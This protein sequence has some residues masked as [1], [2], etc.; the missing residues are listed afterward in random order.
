MGATGSK[1]ENYNR[2]QLSRRRRNKFGAPEPPGIESD[3]LVSVFEW[4]Y[5]DLNEPIQTNGDTFP[6]IPAGIANKTMENLRNELLLPPGGWP[7]SPQTLQNSIKVVD[8]DQPDEIPVGVLTPR[9][10]KLNINRNGDDKNINKDVIAEAKYLHENFGGHKPEMVAGTK[11]NKNMGRNQS[12]EKITY[13][14]YCNPYLDNGKQRKDAH[15][16]YCGYPLW[17]KGV[18]IHSS[19]V[20]DIKNMFLYLDTYDL[21]KN[22]YPMHSTCNAYESKLPDGI[23]GVLNRLGSGVP[24]LESNA[25]GVGMSFAEHFLK[26]MPELF[27][28][29]NALYDATPKT[30]DELFECFKRILG[31]LKIHRGLLQKDSDGNKSS[32]VYIPSLP[33]STSSKFGQLYVDRLSA[34]ENLDVWKIQKI[35][36]MIAQGVIREKEEA[37]DIDVQATIEK[38]E[39]LL[40]EKNNQEEQ[41]RIDLRNQEEKLEAIREDMGDITADNVISNLEKSIAE[42][43]AEIIK[44]LLNKTEEE[45]NASRAA[46]G[47]A[48]EALT[49][50]QVRRFNDWSEHATADDLD[51][52]N[53][54]LIEKLRRALERCNEKM[55]KN[56]PAGSPFKPSPNKSGTMPLT[57]AAAAAGPYDKKH[58]R[59]VS[60][61][62]EFGKSNN[63]KSTKMSVAH[64][65][66][67]LQLKKYK[68]RVTKTLRGKRM[69]LTF[70]EAS[71]A[72]KRYLTVAKK[73]KKYSIVVTKTIRGKR[74]PRTENEMKK[75]LQRFKRFTTFAIRN[76]IRVTR[77][78]NGKRKYKTINQLRNDILRFKKEKAKLIRRSRK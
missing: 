37:G 29:G 18:G 7:N 67:L 51:K 55:L 65:K 4:F 72:L 8:S 27:D 32:P 73:A 6:E 47:K 60:S 62:S 21:Q 76:K 12:R 38:Y 57:A 33:L 13:P 63:T 25:E 44:D 1:Q 59:A 70:K 64:K 61:D 69:Y 45:L 2:A 17:I 14:V 78:V 52:E 39:R 30:Q 77:T 46:E 35:N 34:S 28:I 9:D 42:K 26:E 56:N 48:K 23:Y 50:E 24:G 75:D 58:P 31:D 20:I 36:L 74:L 68:L 11:L 10:Y 22:W 5:N 16:L 3:D 66:K 19:H 15:C 41:L 40:D 43:K 49:D 71:S 54:K 53:N